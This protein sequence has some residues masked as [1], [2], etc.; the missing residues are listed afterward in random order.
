MTTTN[1][2][3]GGN[4]PID[5][6]AL[7]QQVFADDP[8]AVALA[9]F[10]KGELPAATFMVDEF[11]RAA[12]AA[13]AAELAAPTVRE[14]EPATEA[15]GDTEPVAAQVEVADED[16]PDADTHLWPALVDEKGRATGELARPNPEAMRVAM[17]RAAATSADD[18]AVLAEAISEPEARDIIDLAVELRGVERELGGKVTRRRLE[19][20]SESARKQAEHDAHLADVR[21]RRENRTAAALERRARALDPTSRIVRLAAAERI[22]PWIAVLPAALA[23]VLGAVNV[24]VQLDALSPGTHVI[25][26]LV[27]PLITLP[28]V[29]ILI[30]QILGAVGAGDKNPYRNLEWALVLVAV[31]L[32]VGLHA[33]VDGRFTA[34]AA[35]WIIVPGGFAISAHLVPKLIGAV[36]E[37]LADASVE[38]TAVPTRAFATT[39]NR[40][41]STW[42]VPEP[43]QVSAESTPELRTEDE[44]LA[45]FADAVQNGRIDPGT[46][47]EMDPTSAES[48]RRTLSVGKARG[49]ALRDEFAK[50]TTK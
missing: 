26:W 25:N 23:A 20:A 3:A 19:L 30:A 41:E 10:D 48:I 44:I 46:G 39:A 45:E 8:L 28:I 5:W 4:E 33:L 50:R 2:A 27:E 9:A 47:K 38:T 43:P 24:G 22:V 32:N 6:N 18:V 21:R 36:R 16:D 31:G 34:A 13:A 40:S 12:S 49:R 42:T 15:E 37:A 7:N 1:A 35:V 14:L 11:N 17:K 29:A